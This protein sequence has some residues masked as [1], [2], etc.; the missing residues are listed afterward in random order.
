MQI[1]SVFLKHVF[2]VGR[3]CSYL[4]SIWAAGCPLK[5]KQTNLNYECQKHHNSF[6]LG[7]DHY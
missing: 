3:I 6:E 5:E 7:F 4:G 2:Q 1:F